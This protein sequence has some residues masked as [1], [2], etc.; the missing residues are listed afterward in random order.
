MT[1]CSWVDANLLS[2]FRMETLV[3]IQILRKPLDR[4]L[5]N[6]LHPKPSGQSLRAK[7]RT[8]ASHKAIAC[9][10]PLNLRQSHA[11]HKFLKGTRFKSVPQ[12]FWA[13]TFYGR[14][15]TTQ[16]PPRNTYV[17]HELFK[18][19]CVSFLHSRRDQEANNNS[20]IIY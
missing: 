7:L 17:E 8:L 13:Q 11:W 14:I 9:K 19:H 15:R 12:N 5:K 18:I 10:S 3:P 4:K 1:P 16:I 6:C 2:I 20:I